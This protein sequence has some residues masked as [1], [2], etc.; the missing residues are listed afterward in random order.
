MANPKDRLALF[1]T[2]EDQT[3]RI[4]KE[5][6]VKIGFNEAVILMQLEYLIS[7][8]R[9]HL[10]DNWWTYQALEELKEK[11]F[12]WWSIATISRAMKS[13]EKQELIFID[14]FN[15]RGGDQTRW[16]ALNIEKIKEL[17]I[18]KFNDKHPIFQIEKWLGIEEQKEAETEPESLPIL[19]NDEAIFHFA[20]GILQ[21]ETT[22]PEITTEISTEDILSNDNSGNS[23]PPEIKN[24]LEPDT[25]ETILLFEKF[26]QNRS[27]EGR[28]AARK[29]KTLEQKDKCIKAAKRLG[30]E[31][32]SEG[33]E[34][35]L[36]QGIT[37]IAGLVNWVAKWGYHRNGANN[38]HKNAYQPT[39]SRGTAPPS[40]QATG[41][42]E[43]FDIPIRGLSP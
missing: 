25:P 30:L 28:R 24:Q 40:S 38:G 1:D 17:G 35:G 18:I 21:D 4:Q 32:F 23:P 3:L 2:T 7:I 16:Y 19:Q 10:K 39:R 34:A 6:A 29:F 37:N 20:R 26:N 14:N 31:R 22:L 43:G 11:Y 36:E 41:L 12:P 5:L 15:K 8:S 33:L 9:H 27:A 42:G 13:L